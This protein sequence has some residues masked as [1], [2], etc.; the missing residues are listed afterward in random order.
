[1]NTKLILNF[2]TD[3]SN[4]NSLDWMHANK[5]AYKEAYDEFAELVQELIVLLSESDPSIRYL[6]SH[7]LIFRLNR[8]TRFSHDKSP[9]SPSFRAHIS[10]GGKLPVPVGYFIN[11][12]PD[13]IF[14]G[15]G[16]FASQFKDATTMIRD[17]IVKHGDELEQILSDPE[18][19]KYYTLM[20]E[21][22]KNI[23][24]GYEDHTQYGEYLKYKS[25]FIESHISPDGFLNAEQFL[26]TAK[27]QFIRMKPFNDY[28]NKALVDFKMPTR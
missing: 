10:S 6:N 25:W 9:Y 12:T 15:G 11:I 28:L 19:S 3:L 16:L 23:P 5:P 4:N 18:F 14:L 7:D 21:Q 1:M 24:R 17:Y 26:A 8:D 13:D 22:L 20:G 27:E 2:L